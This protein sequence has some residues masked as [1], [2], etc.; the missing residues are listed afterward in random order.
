MLNKRHPKIFQNAKALQQ[1]ESFKRHDSFRSQNSPCSPSLQ[2]YR[3]GIRI[4]FERNE[5]PGPV[6]NSSV[7]CLP[8]YCQ[9]KKMTAINQ[10]DIFLHKEKPE[11]YNG[12]NYST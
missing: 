2:S 3:R 11:I 5:L 6:P 8:R 9:R 1:I 4:D 12:G 10:Q 7:K